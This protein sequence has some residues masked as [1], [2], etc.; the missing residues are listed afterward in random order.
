MSL[1][2]S[3]LWNWLTVRFC[4]CIGNT[5][6]NYSITLMIAVSESRRVH[7]WQ[8]LKML[9]WYISRFLYL[10][11]F[12]IWLLVSL[13]HLNQPQVSPPISLL[14]PLASDSQVP[15]CLWRPCWSW[16]PSNNFCKVFPHWILV[17]LQSEHCRNGRGWISLCVCGGQLCQPASCAAQAESEATAGWS[18]SDPAVPAGEPGIVRNGHR[19]LPHLP[20]LPSWICEYLP[21]VWVWTCL[22]NL[23]QCHPLISYKL[24]VTVLFFPLF[25]ALWFSLWMSFYTLFSLSVFFFTAS[26]L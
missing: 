21:R 13:L 22:Q 17:Q 5:N 7:P 11:L 23:S 9:W 18:G 10:S 2:T 20:S 25:E 24:R 3:R 26:F 4:S 1:F 12:F 8:P 19:S 6:I 15:V 16:V 14:L